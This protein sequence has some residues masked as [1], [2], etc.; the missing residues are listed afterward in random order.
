M[1]E[2][3]HLDRGKWARLRFKARHSAAHR[4]PDTTPQQAD[5]D[6][7]HLQNWLR[8]LAR[9][10]DTHDPAEEPQAVHEASTSP[11]AAQQRHP[12]AGTA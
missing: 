3:R 11:A 9:R 6:E 8:T 10:V 7:Q 2:P 1:S 12:A 5:S 4:A